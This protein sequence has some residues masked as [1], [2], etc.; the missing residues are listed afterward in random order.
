MAIWR[1]IIIIYLIMINCDISSACT[2]FQIKPAGFRLVTFG[3]IGV[4]RMVFFDRHDEMG[5]G[6][7]DLLRTYL[8]NVLPTSQFC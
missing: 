1:S 5:N 7:I 8:F 2:Y 6:W 4:D 3:L